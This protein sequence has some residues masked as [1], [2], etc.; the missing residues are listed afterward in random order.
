[1]NKILHFASKIQFTFRKF[2]NH[3]ENNKYLKFYDFLMTFR[4]RMLKLF[5]CFSKLDRAQFEETE[6]NF[7][8]SKL[9]HS[10]EKGTT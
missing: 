5:E 4:H 9:K 10:K 7:L 2:A 8:G 6:T 1:M 3:R